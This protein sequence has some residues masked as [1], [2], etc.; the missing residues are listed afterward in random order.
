MDDLAA[1]YQG[2]N[3]GDAGDVAETLAI[4]EGERFR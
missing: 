2:I 3:T 1:G 4:A